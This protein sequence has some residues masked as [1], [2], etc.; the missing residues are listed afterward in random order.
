MRGTMLALI[1]QITYEVSIC[2]SKSNQRDIFDSLYKKKLLN[3]RC[4]SMRYISKYF[5]YFSIASLRTMPL[6]LFPWRI[7]FV[8]ICYRKWFYKQENVKTIQYPFITLIAYRESQWKSQGQISKASSIIVHGVC[9]EFQCISND[10]LFICPSIYNVFFRAYC[11]V[12]IKSL[13]KVLLTVL[14]HVL[15]LSY[16]MQSYVFFTCFL[17]MF[18]TLPI[19]ICCKIP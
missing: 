11:S 16:L 9:M 8:N 1:K 13:I 14:K 2:V 3:F 18:C 7:Y 4:L 17:S 15:F 10:T 5:N 6:M 12:E 19:D